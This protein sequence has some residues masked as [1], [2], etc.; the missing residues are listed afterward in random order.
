MTTIHS[1][2]V[3]ID[4]YPALVAPPL[5]GC[6]NDIDGVRRLLERRVAASEPR[7]LLD[8]EATVEAVGTGIRDGLGAAGP[9]D[10]ALLWFSGHGTRLPAHGADLLIEATGHN[11]ALVCADGPLPDKRL[12]VLLDEVAARGARVVAV[13]DCCFSGGATRD[14][15]LTARYAPVREAWGRAAPAPARDAAPARPAGAG[16]DEVLLLAASRADQQ[17]HETYFDGRRYGVFT[18][19]VLD[20][21][22]EAP[23]G[24]SYREVLSAADARVQCAGGRQQPVLFPPGPGGTADRPFL[25]DAA[26]RTAVAHLLRHGAAGWEVDCGAG[27][28][29]RED[30]PEGAA[31][32][33][34]AVVDE[35]PWQAGHSAP[36]RAGTETT[37][38]GTGRV[39]TARTVLPDRTLV[40]PVDWAPAPERVYPVALTALNLPPA[41]VT[42]VPAG[43]PAPGPGDGLGAALDR[44]LATAGPGGGP[45]P[46][47][48]T[49]ADPRQAGD[50]HFRLERR[51]PA[52][53]VSRRDGSRFV[54]PLPL[55]APEDVR[56]IADCLIHLTRWH[57]LRNLAPRPSPLDG[58]VR[59]EVGAWGAPAG[60]PLVP[61][62]SGEIVCAYTPGRGGHPEPPLLSIRLRNRSRDR[63]LWCLLLDLTDGYGSH[64]ALYPGHFIAPGHT[65]H[66][67]DGEPV[68]FS[69]P[70]GRA[71]VPGAEARDWLKLVVAECELNTVPF[72]LPAWA[73]ERAASRTSRP[74][75]GDGVLRFSPLP[76]APGTRDLGGVT[77]RPYGHWTTRTLT[78]RTVVPAS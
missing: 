67:L 58:L 60:R 16:G 10:T 5:G 32:A 55:S 71:P 66:A 53:H 63:A 11:Q 65:G 74:D 4:D 26:A 57:R 46:L 27:H 70:A 2:L 73:P 77:T 7:V 75:G 37:P 28:G 49:V 56:R 31:A 76:P 64:A 42:V 9:G 45:S 40:D 25:A 62:G 15:V 59:V 13:L 72:H 50:L 29:L 33:E 8:R 17:A 61:D 24:V 51:G 69:L 44:A 39:L 52:V 43:P 12:R 35:E 1:L 68:R 14:P 54:A 21:V 78:L 34:F 30:A 41:T 3:G 19:A 20:A 36:V 48:R 47:L 6:L 38:A 18:R 23:A 22:R